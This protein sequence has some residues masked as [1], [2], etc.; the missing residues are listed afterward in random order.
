MLPPCYKALGD[1]EGARRATKL[2]LARTE[3][4]V[5]QD[6]N[7]GSA[8]GFAI[9]ALAT[10]GESARA[11]DLIQR[12]TLL[13]PENLNMRY[14]LACAT[15]IDLKDAEGGLDLLKPL[16]EIVPKELLNWTKAD[17]DMDSVR[18]HPRFKAMIA[19]AEA[20]LA[21]EGSSPAPHKQ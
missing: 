15:I 10:L 19:A 2:A 16:L 3:P 11:K 6:P 4:L 17:P 13:D 5:A 1:L 20:R 9:G 21:A 12:A 7:N 8:M 18:D 14:N